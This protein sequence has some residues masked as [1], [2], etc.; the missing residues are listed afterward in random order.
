MSTIGN[1]SP[2]F[3]RRHEKSNISKLSSNYSKA[4]TGGTPG[5]RYPRI[6]ASR[7]P[8]TPS[9]PLDKDTELHMRKTT[10]LEKVDE[11]QSLWNYWIATLRSPRV[12]RLVRNGLIISV[13][14]LM[15][16][17]LVP[18]NRIVWYKFSIV[19]HSSSFNETEARENLVGKK[20]EKEG[21]MR[22]SNHSE[23]DDLQ[24]DPMYELIL[25]LNVLT[26]LN[27]GPEL[28]A[29]QGAYADNR[30]I[31]MNLTQGIPDLSVDSQN[32]TAS[33]KD[34][35]KSMWNFSEA[36][37]DYVGFLEMILNNLQEE[38]KNLQ[39]ALSKI[40]P[41]DT[42]HNRPDLEQGR[43]IAALWITHYEWLTSEIDNLWE[44]TLRFQD[45][46]K[47]AVKQR[48]D[49]EEAFEITQSRMTKEAKQRDLKNFDFPAAYKF[50]RRF[51]YVDSLD[52]EDE[53]QDGYETR[54]EYIMLPF[55]RT[56]E[57]ANGEAKYVMEK[58]QRSYI[59]SSTTGSQD[60]TEGNGNKTNNATPL[61]PF[62]IPDLGQQIEVLRATYESYVQVKIYLNDM[63]HD[64]ARRLKGT[65][66][67]PLL[68]GE[69]IQVY[70]YV[71]SGQQDNAYMERQSDKVKE[72]INE[73]NEERKR[74][75]YKRYMEQEE[76]RKKKNWKPWNF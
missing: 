75:R 49:L 34:F 63:K 16:V 76:K 47:D 9:P 21:M 65:V 44:E 60:E 17:S 58:L 31:I 52:L 48:I 50:I 30:Y 20:R 13:L 28:E 67:M 54:L 1:L 73:K 35:R 42:W 33:L 71:L 61:A 69:R 68:P 29:L 45:E 41:E 37:G 70:D 56:L 11:I 39:I 5:P 53:T 8:R 10:W 64:L 23:L 15:A 12:M 51:S 26:R 25:P 46:A 22:K 24:R 7:P 19:T 59:Q 40:Q 55:S 62:E 18:W 3:R 32:L 27:I 57:L 72:V 36:I 38:S 2:S 14:F 4:S 66:L 74:L 43:K 6:V